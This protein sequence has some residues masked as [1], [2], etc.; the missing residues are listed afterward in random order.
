MSSQSITAKI[1][2]YDPSVDTEP[3][4]SVYEVPWVEDE[5]GIM[6]ALQVLHAINQDQEQIGYDYC[7]RTGLCGRCSMLIDGKAGLACW[8]SL[9]PGTHIFEPL[10]GFPVIKDLVV[11]KN[12]GYDRIHS[13]DLSVQSV[14]P[15]VELKPIDHYL[16]WNTLERLNMCRECMC[17]MSICPQLKVSGNDYIGPAPMMAIAQRYLDTQDESD[18]L[19]QAVNAGLFS[20]I[21][22][23]SCESVCPSFIG[24]T[25]I[26]KK[27]QNDAIKRGIQPTVTIDRC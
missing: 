22:C 12:W 13:V 8:T 25:D 24:F 11:D 23:S 16:W 15:I 18:R 26:I 3:T 4:E 17:C 14:N 27:M 19:M 5:S 20:C 2:K 6:T 7:C 9:S 10:P 21:L 1:F